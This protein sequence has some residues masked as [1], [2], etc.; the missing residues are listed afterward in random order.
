[1]C[2]QAN[3]GRNVPESFSKSIEDVESDIEAIGALIC[4]MVAVLREQDDPYGGVQ[5]VLVLLEL[6]ND[7]RRSLLDAYAR[8][9][10]TAE[11]GGGR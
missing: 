8:L 2:E 6:L 10:L 11:D 3:D 5:H 1:M 7:K 9:W 4:A